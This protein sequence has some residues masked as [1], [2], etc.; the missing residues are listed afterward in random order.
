[1]TISQG[2]SRESSITVAVR[3]R[4]FTA[5]E[6]SRLIVKQDDQQLLGDGAFSGRPNNNNN[7]N[8]SNNNS[9]NNNGNNNNSGSSDSFRAGDN[10]FGLKGIRKI[11][12]VVDERMLIFDPAD[13]N[14]LQKMQQTLF[15]KSNS[16]MREHKFTFDRLFDEDAAQIDVYNNTTRPLLDSVLDG[17]NA[18]VFAYGATGC[19]KTHTITGT[20]DDPG[21]IYTTTQELFERIEALKDTKT[22]E[23][24]LSYLEIYNE[25]IRD[26]LNPEIEHRLL[27]I[28]EDGNN[29]IS[30]RNLSNHKLTTVEEIMDLILLGNSNRT[31]NFTEANATSSRSHAV[32]QINIDQRNRTRGINEEHFFAT[33]SIID[34]AGSERASS[35]KNQGKRLH[36][37]ANINRS[38]LAL[39]NCINALCDPKRRNHIPYRDSKLTRLLKFSLG[40]NCKT[41]MIV[42]VSPSSQHYEE[43]LNTLKYANRAKEIKTKV[44]RNT[45]NLDRHVGSYLKMITE[46]KQEIEELRTR[47][48]KVIKQQLDSFKL[49]KEKCGLNLLES[50][51]ILKNLIQ[52]K[53]PQLLQKSKLLTKK[54]ML[55]F[56]KSEIMLLLKSFESNYGSKF[57]NVPRD[58]LDVR[59][60]I[61]KIIDNISKEIEM[62]DIFLSKDT[63][64]EKNLNKT[65]KLHQAK[66]KE[67]EGWSDYDTLIFDLL[68][69]Q[70]KNNVDRQVLDKANK[71]WDSIVGE[72]NENTSQT[73]N[74]LS[75]TFFKVHK[76]LT[77][78][79]TTGDIDVIRDENLSLINGMLNDC[80]KVLDANMGSEYVNNLLAQVD[81]GKK[82]TGKR[83][84]SPT[85]LS[86][87]KSSR[88]GN[89]TIRTKSPKR[90]NVHKIKKVVRWDLPAS[91]TVVYNHTDSSEDSEGG[92][93]SS[94]EEDETMDDVIE[95]TMS[96]PEQAKF[97][98]NSETKP[99]LRS[100]TRFVKKVVDDT[101]EDYS[102]IDDSKA[103]TNFGQQKPSLTEISLKPPENLLGSISESDVSKSS[104]DIPMNDK[105][106]LGYF[107]QGYSQNNQ[108]SPGLL[109]SYKKDD[110]P[111]IGP[112]IRLNR[113]TGSPTKLSPNN[114][115]FAITS[116]PKVSNIDKFNFETSF[117][118]DIDMD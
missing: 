92:D 59:E 113:S 41:V 90:K 111:G 19:G 115:T 49:K 37:G 30:V 10:R 18:T 83:L 91:S 43:T 108:I 80:Y 8:N 86:P 93:D 101:I 105:E 95:P 34:L 20:P 44:I 98:F 109:R 21:I 6:S 64:F 63:D 116:P 9:N 61:K 36:E 4:P 70:M 51:D 84:S 118:G 55:S 31:I 69:G 88:N 54:R 106:N 97:T 26:L 100:P 65:I 29:R 68:V 107:G 23:V 72:K 22:I 67:L 17:Y 13:E 78:I 32:L 48:A 117:S 76:K 99:F 58:L 35:T 75:N 94:Q 14:P 38:L 73:F 56:Q 71:V 77:F 82:S 112:P 1:M 11:V 110:N 39:G 33:L 87:H 3:V 24:S 25:T 45:H 27:T 114:D 53:Q 28:R 104:L 47:E 89:V 57:V 15:P 50:V 102:M 66:L 46:Q 7:N 74:C 103:F 2:P 40:G 12:N 52:T 85:K 5:T 16:R 62:T 60:A 96:V 42:C 79:N 81:I